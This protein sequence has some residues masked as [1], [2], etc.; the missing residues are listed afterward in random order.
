MQAA[1]GVS[2]PV[3]DRAAAA[4]EHA[5]E[6]ALRRAPRPEAA[7]RRAR[8][9]R[10]G[11]PVAVVGEGGVRRTIIIRPTSPQDVYYYS[12]RSVAAT[13]PPARL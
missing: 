4:Q 6:P 2:M 5:D 10:D 13:P 7:P 12:R 1:A 11:I 9:S 3:P 8:A